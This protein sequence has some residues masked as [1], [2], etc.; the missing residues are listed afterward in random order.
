MSVLL[1]VVVILGVVG[2][3]GPVIAGAYL[4]TRLNQRELP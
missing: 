1:I 4:A 2:L 3:F